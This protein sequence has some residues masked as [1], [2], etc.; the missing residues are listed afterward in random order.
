MC[1]FIGISIMQIILSKQCKALTGTIYSRCGY[2]IHQRKS[3]FYGVRNSKG[4]VPDDGHWRFILACANLAQTKLYVTDIL[5]PRKEL[6]DA[7][8]EAHH[9]LAA[10]NL[11]LE[12]YHANDILNLKKT[13]S[14]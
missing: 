12:F 9:F 8:W 3:G 1:S 10:Q 13:F 2:Y 11:R 6:C 14:L 5:V 7:L 4:K